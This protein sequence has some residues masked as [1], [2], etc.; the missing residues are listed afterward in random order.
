MT[1]KEFYRIYYGSDKVR[2]VIRRQFRDASY[3]VGSGPA[4]IKKKWTFPVKIGEVGQLEQFLDEGLDIYRPALSAF[5]D[6]FIFWDLEYFNRQDRKFVYKKQREVFAK[7]S[8]I[9]SEICSFLDSFGIRYIID[10]TASGV[11]FWMKISKSSAAFRSLAEEG[12][13]TQSILKKYE[14]LDPSDI[15][16]RKRVPVDVAAAYDAAGKVLEFITQVIRQ[17][18]SKR[19]GIPFTVSD[20]PDD[21][22]NPEGFSSDITQYGHPIFMRVFRVMASLHQKSVMFYGGASP[23][24]DIVK[25]KEMSFDEVLDRMW[26]AQKAADFYI[27]FDPEVPK[28]DE[29]WKKLVEAYKASVV[30]RIHRELESASVRDV[31][32]A[33]LKPEISVFFEKELANP[34]LLDPKILKKIVY[35]YGKDVELVKS[36]FVTIARMYEDDSYGWYDREKLTGID[37][38][39][40]DAYQAAHFWSRVYYTQFVLDGGRTK[41]TAVRIKD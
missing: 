9:I 20:A 11:H 32:P 5:E 30:R 8:P 21:D 7:M 31:I 6:F 26:D 33:D 3:V 19:F 27:N 13:L 14:T 34:S 15:K 28:S 40:Y 39:K 23:S 38:K 4:L 2:D 18:K 17:E 24:A 1:L 36:I 37:W 22:D 41:K 25:K 16:R 29:G 35:E 12:Y 10:T